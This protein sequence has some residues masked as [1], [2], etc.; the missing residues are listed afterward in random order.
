MEK[1]SW[2][3]FYEA[4]NEWPKLYLLPYVCSR[5]QH[6]CFKVWTCCFP[7]LCYK[8]SPSSPE[9]YKACLTSTST[10][11][12][13]TEHCLSWQRCLFFFICFLFSHLFSHSC[14]KSG[15]PC[16]FWL[17]H[18]PV[19]NGVTQG[20]HFVGETLYTS[21]AKTKQPPV[22]EC[23]RSRQCALQQSRCCVGSALR[24][25]ALISSSS[26]YQGPRARPF[27]S[28]DNSFASLGQAPSPEPWRCRAQFLI[29]GSP[30]IGG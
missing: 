21:L 6:P 29:S 1:Q 25:K 3:R 24:G 4:F 15:S 7:K 30:W 13:Q 28:P 26:A 22:L 20:K 19:G 16:Y 27:R 8:F 5:F 14:W 12:L 17:S 2:L 23:L 18:F 10:V 9:A 11:V